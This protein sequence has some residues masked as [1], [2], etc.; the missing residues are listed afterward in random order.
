MAHRAGL[1]DGV[2][3]RAAGELADA[4]GLE[5]LTLA[6]L[7]E[8]LKVRSPSLYKHVGGLDDVRRGVALLGA[9]MLAERFARAA[10]GKSGAAGVR[11]VSVAYR[12]FAKEHPGLYGAIQRAPAQDDAALIAA[13]GEII[14]IL[15]AVLEPW[16]LDETQA[17]HAIRMIR[18]LI[19][20]FVSLEAAGG[21]G[22]PLDLEQSYDYAITVY[23]DG[24]EREAAQRE[25]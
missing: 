12:A 22:I 4:E 24:L 15:R 17:I 5:Q 20:G 3:L 21:F 25:G 18:S 19:H 11:A 1:D 14:D 2:I 9:R 23:I 16:R 13:S 10:I 7:A 6:H 8:R